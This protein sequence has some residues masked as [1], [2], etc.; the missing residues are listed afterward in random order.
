MER[1]AMR[2][3][4]DY[5][6]SSAEMSSDGSTLQKLVQTAT[7]VAGETDKVTAAIASL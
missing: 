5:S 1:F 2:G 7:T 3:E 4:C 6:D